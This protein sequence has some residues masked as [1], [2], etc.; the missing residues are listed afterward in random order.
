MC[1]KCGYTT[2][3]TNTAARNAQKVQTESMIGSTSTAHIGNLM[4]GLW[5]QQEN[6]TSAPSTNKNTT[7]PQDTETAENPKEQEEKVKTLL[8]ET[9]FNALS[10][11]VKEEVL[12]KY[13]TITTYS[14]NNGIEVSDTEMARR[15]NNFIKAL[16]SHSKEMKMG[17]YFVNGGFADEYNGETIVDENVRQQKATG[18]DEEYFQSLLDR[19][20]GTVQLYDTNGDNVVSESEFLEKEAS[21]WKQLT[22]ENVTDE[23]TSASKDYFN[24]ID[25]NK[26]GTLDS[27]ELGT[28]EYARATLGDTDKNT[29]DE[30]TFK[31]W[32]L[33]ST[34]G[35]NEAITSRYNYAS[36]Q[37]YKYL[38]NQQEK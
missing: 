32:Y 18:T 31:E 28:H 22:G 11:E 6:N 35:T 10:D 19:G 38:N 37:I 27:A 12:K 15:L 34:V 4:N 2:V 13:S 36:D 3:N 5:R 21:D 17:E 7:V 20:N 14:K 29:N 9:T 1:T 23:M 25:K 30:L 33:G 8:G 26:N 16:D 24:K